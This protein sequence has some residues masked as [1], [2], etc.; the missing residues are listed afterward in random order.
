MP[1]ENI[2]VLT[3]YTPNN[4]ASNYMW[5]KLI[6][7]QGEIDKTTIII[8]DVNTPLS[9]IDPAGRKSVRT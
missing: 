7:V 8:G 5:Q 3:T 6:D 9:E 2:T 4:R 1:Q